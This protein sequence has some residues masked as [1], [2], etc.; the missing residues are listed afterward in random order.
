MNESKDY[1]DETFELMEKYFWSK[2]YELYSDE[3]SAD[4]SNVS[5]Y[6]GQNAN[7]HSCEALISAFEATNEQKYLDRHILLQI[8]S[9]INK[10][11]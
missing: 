9:V 8:I 3:I 7:M 4:W 11:V 2:E 1:I 6:R 10:P 5:K